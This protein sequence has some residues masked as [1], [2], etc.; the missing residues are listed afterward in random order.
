MYTYN[1]NLS[2]SHRF[3]LLIINKNDVK[4]TKLMALHD[5]YE[6]LY[7]DNFNTGL[8]MARE[9]TPSLLIINTLLPENDFRVQ[10]KKTLRTSR[11]PVLA[12]IDKEEMHTLPQSVLAGCDD[13][14]QSS[15]EEAELLL[16]VRMMLA[17]KLQLHERY[18]DFVPEGNMET[19]RDLFVKR[20]KGIIEENLNNN[21]FG[22]SDLACE[23][24]VSKP[25]LYR[26]LIAITG[27]S[28]NTY[29][30]HIRLK[31]AARL[32]EVGA[33]NVGEIAY[34]VGFNSHSYFAKCFKAAHQYNPKQVLG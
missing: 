2:C 31:H 27:F 13:F 21:L 20:I 10:L 30:R 7:A 24:G 33:G 5:S 11:I 14:I 23:A 19:T 25:Q 28:P 34:R 18:I 6:V 32:L 17:H 8:S 16:R 12:I 15:F 4:C 1:K 26:K 22:V 3:R 29:I 9:Q